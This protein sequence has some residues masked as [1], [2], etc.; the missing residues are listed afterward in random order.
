MRGS[1]LHGIAWLGVG[2]ALL[3]Q[4][5]FIAVIGVWL[6]APQ[7]AAERFPAHVAS[8]VVAVG[9]VAAGLGAVF[10]GT[11]GISAARRRR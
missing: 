8:G 4:A 7:T 9:F 2:I 3:A 1:L 6:E 5:A 10:L 11:R